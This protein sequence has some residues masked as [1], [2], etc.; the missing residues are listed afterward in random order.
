MGAGGKQ[1]NV[2]DWKSAEL[3]TSARKIQSGA[4]A[5]NHSAQL[6]CSPLH[7]QLSGQGCKG[8]S[9]YA[10]YSLFFVG[11]SGRMRLFPLYSHILGFGTFSSVHW[12]WVFYIAVTL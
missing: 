4:K 2:A 11:N 6:Q 10:V 9:A 8:A 3:H 7:S 5:Q 1:L 12:G